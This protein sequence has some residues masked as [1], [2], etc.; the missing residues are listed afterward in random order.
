LLEHAMKDLVVWITG[1]GSG[2]GEALALELGGRGCLVAVSGRRRDR[3]D[4]VAARVEKAGGRCLAVPCDVTD[5]SDVARA[6]AEILASWQRLDICVANAGYGVAAPFEAVTADQWRRQLEVNV[7]GTAITL[8]A[9][10]PELRKTAGRAVV[11]SSVLG[12]L[13]IA[14]SAPYVASKFALVGL[15]DTLSLELRGTGVTVTNILPGLVATEIAQVDNDGQFRSDRKDFRP[16]AVMWTAARSA[17]VMADA[18][19]ARKR[20]FVFTAHGK[21][22]AFLGRHAP[23]ALY[24]AMGRVG[25]RGRG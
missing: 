21:V 2:L 14:G 11:V 16:K 24:W 17:R 22:A 8:R 18:I 25:V 5:E 9:A 15:C 12:R 19:E 1:G 10:L 23:G 4:A 20:E 13:G 6:L 3:L 7:V